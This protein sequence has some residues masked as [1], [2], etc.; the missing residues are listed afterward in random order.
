M[1]GSIASQHSVEH[2]RPI[3]QMVLKSGS[4]MD[5]RIA[6]L[7]SVQQ[8]WPILHMI[9]KSRRDMDGQ[10][11]LLHSI[12]H[13]WP[14]K[15]IVSRTVRYQTEPVTDH[16]PHTALFWPSDDTKQQ[17]VKEATK[18]YRGYGMDSTISR[19]CSTLP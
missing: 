16:M 2:R 1:V 3:K 10:I 18:L 6:P 13:H 7:H 9:L 17:H 11:A 8:R 5:G 14:N 12:K 4:D 15:R 19:V